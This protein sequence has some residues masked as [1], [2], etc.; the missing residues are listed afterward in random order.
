MEF[1]RTINILLMTGSLLSSVNAIETKGFDISTGDYQRADKYA[2]INTGIIVIGFLT[3]IAGV[4][5]NQ[6]VPA[7]VGSLAQAIS[8]PLL[9]LNAN[10][11][12]Q[13]LANRNTAFQNPTTGWY[14]YGGGFLFGFAGS[15]LLSS[16]NEDYNNR[17]DKNGN[18]NKDAGKLKVISGATLFLS[19]AILSTT[20]FFLFE[21]KVSKCR[22]FNA[23]IS[24]SPIIVNEGEK[25]FVGLNI[26]HQF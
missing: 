9:G 11:M 24:F 16:G 21:R 2:S 17:Y 13:Y 19:G 14:L 5:I 22:Q 18:E 26:G 20:A 6:P 12:G 23:D 7:F 8:F 4:A 15:L 1:N 25:I 3:S 10:T